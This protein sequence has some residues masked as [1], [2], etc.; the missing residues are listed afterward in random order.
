MRR[1]E[2]I[3]GSVA[4]TQARAGD[5]LHSHGFHSLY[6]LDYDQAIEAFE[7]ESKQDAEGDAH[8]NLGSALLYRALFRA[9]ALDG[10]VALSVAEFLHK[11]KVAIATEDRNRL[12]RALD[13]GE[14]IARGNVAKNPKN[15][16]A[17]YTLGA[18]FVHRA[19]LA[20]LADKDWRKAL[21]AG[22]EARTLHTQALELD[23]GLIDAMLV[24]S[25]HE[26]IVG[27][28][29][30]FL[31]ALGF[32]IGFSGDKEKGLAGLRTVASKGTRAKL[33]AELVLALVE[34][35]ERRPEL[36]LPIMQRLIQE[37]PVN[38]LYRHEV[39]NLL[40]DMTLKDEARREF[41]Q[42]GDARYKFLKPTSLE[43]YKREFEARLRA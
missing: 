29:P 28:L 23:R 42:L 33:E 39:A 6:N 26:Y 1:R 9:D 3:A 38:H 19:N 13:R 10:K 21:K 36:A 22:G 4:A 12:L 34:R 20:L 37:Y 31:R 8:N 43:A 27:S 41:A 16:N 25:V 11:P 24:P 5:Y 17:L 2:F 35:R 30:I 18:S 15:A 7:A 32:L 40:L 14:E